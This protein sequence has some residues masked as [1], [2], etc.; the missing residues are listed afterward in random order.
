MLPDLLEN[1][2]S[3]RP[4]MA[5]AIYAHLAVCSGCAR[6]FDQMQ[7]VIA[8]IEALPPAEMP[9]DYSGLIMQQIQAKV[10]AKSEAKTDAHGAKTAA[11]SFPNT[12][13]AAQTLSKTVTPTARPVGVS[14]TVQTTASRLSSEQQSQLTTQ[15]GVQVWQRLTIGAMLSGM[16]AFF[17]NSA[18][19][20][21]M[22]GVNLA[23]ATAWLEQI[24]ESMSRMP[25]MGGIVG[26]VF[27]ALAQTS[28]LLSETYHS[29]GSLAARGLALD[30][31]MAA[32]AYYYVLNRRQREQR[33]G[34]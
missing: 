25:V 32:L 4:E 17:L 16:L 29:L 24:G 3:V 13:S 19:G 30:I 8:R 31:A 18:W 20:R 34:V 7:R 33:L 6:E 28:G 10:E 27:S 9:M 22:L 14:T 1:D 2:G 26:L 21:Q 11:R 23:N 15:T 12:V 5:T